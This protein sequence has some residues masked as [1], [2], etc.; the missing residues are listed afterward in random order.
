M[1]SDDG[2][3]GNARVDAALKKAKGNGSKEASAAPSAAES[4]K[5]MASDASEQARGFIGHWPYTSVIATFALGL[6]F[7][8][9]AG[10]K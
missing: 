10:G 3:T 6:F 5:K 4:A 7:G 9:M 8:A 2:M 1:L